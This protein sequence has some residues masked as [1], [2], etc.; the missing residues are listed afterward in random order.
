MKYIKIITIALSLTFAF[1]GCA[2]ENHYKRNIPFGYIN[3]ELEST[4]ISRIS[5]IYEKAAKTNELE[6][7]KSLI[8]EKEEYMKLFKE[9][10]GFSLPN[11]FVLPKNP[12]EIDWDIYITERYIEVDGLFFVEKE[13][14]LELL[15]HL[16][17]DTRWKARFND[18][19]MVASNQKQ[20]EKCTAF[21]RSATFDH[22]ITSDV[23]LWFYYKEGEDCYALRLLSNL[24]RDPPPG[25][26]WPDR[27][28]NI[29]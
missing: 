7:D 14:A 24:E 16:R 19:G 8:E 17:K 3:P 20:R 25:T 29:H 26:S 10:C 12:E 23:Y 18:L 2:N 15:E 21:E 22:S 28:L 6:E 27:W 9:F 5:D 13:D 11:Y 4:H 1:T